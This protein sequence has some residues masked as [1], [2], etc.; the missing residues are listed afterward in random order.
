M[1]ILKASY[2][3]SS[4]DHEKC[5]PPD[6]P[7]YAFI[8]RSNVGKSSLINALTGFGSLAKTSS[9]PGKTQVINHFMINDTWYLVDLPGY[10][11]AKASKASRDRFND[12]VRDYIWQAQQLKLASLGR[13]T[14]SIAHEVNNPLNFVKN[15]LPPLETAVAALPPGEES[16][17]AQA[18]LRIFKP[19][20]RPGSG[21]LS[22][23]GFLTHSQ[24]S[25][26]GSMA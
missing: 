22:E 17:D 10:G 13:L 12:M 26:R 11:Y 1:K 24:S 16:E 15:A 20:G 18:A 8:G 6:K 14:A 9:K 2:V 19:K 5:P 3:V 4:P 23:V 21:P 7:E 25:V